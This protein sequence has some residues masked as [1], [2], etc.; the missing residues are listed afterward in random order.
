MNF[1]VVNTVFRAR[2][3]N[4]N[5]FSHPLPTNII[6]KQYYGRPH[7]TKFYCPEGRWTALI[8]LKGG[9]RLSRSG[10][11]WPIEEATL[12]FH[13]L[14][15][16]M[17]WR[18]AQPLQLQTCVAVGHIPLPI[19]MTQLAART[20]WIYEPE[21]F[22]AMRVSPLPQSPG[23]CIN[24]F[25][26]GKVII[27]GRNSQSAISTLLDKIQQTVNGSSPQTQQCHAGCGPEPVGQIAI[28]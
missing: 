16:W 27:L 10:G 2:I 28:C 11:E 14:C 7:M 26:S 21:L 22:P 6:I 23:T 24:V 5:Q 12:L 8:F 20:G 19:N 1:T 3:I 9:L 18:I 13:Q 4:K 15:Q 17:D 25:S